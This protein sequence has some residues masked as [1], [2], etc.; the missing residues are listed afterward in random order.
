MATFIEQP[1]GKIRARIRKRGGRTASRTFETK[2]AARAWAAAEEGE[3]ERGTWVNHAVADRHD[4]RPL[5][6]EYRDEVLAKRRSPAPAISRANRFIEDLGHYRLSAVTAPVVADWRDGRAANGL[7]PGTI[8]R[9]LGLL[10]GFFSWV[11][12][13]K[14]IPL[15]AN[16]VSNI[17][18]PSAPPGRERRLKDQEEDWILYAMKDASHES[19]GG[20]RKGNYRRGTRNPVMQK[21]LLFALEAAM[22]EAELA[23]LER[24]FV[25]LK[26]RVAHL[27]GS[28]TKNGEARDV[29]LS[30]K[31]VE[32]LKELGLE[33]DRDGKVF[34]VTA[35]AISQSMT[36]TIRRA[37]QLY[38]QECE[39]QGVPP[40]KGFLEDL[41]FHDMRHESTSRVANKLPNVIE[42]AS[43]TGHKDLRMLKR[44]YHPKAEDLAKKLG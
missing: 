37:R 23:G 35:S 18:K 8:L 34:G 11:M 36:R 5:M 32:I 24:E 3:I 22:R 1:N 6:K 20:K 12:R 4:F 44:Y 17:A 41:V 25:D 2:T 29:P 33:T 38:V 28:I 13:T 7:G 26:R 31:A 15:P 30:T 10:G 43:M 21:V 39:K 40:V 9:E 19:G 27:P 14:M 42:L 16:P